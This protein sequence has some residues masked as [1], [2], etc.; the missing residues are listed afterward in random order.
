MSLG[1][2]KA[3]Q[4]IF[5]T[6]LN[7]LILAFHIIC[8]VLMF[9]QG[10]VNPALHDRALSF[11]EFF[12]YCL[13]RCTIFLRFRIMLQCGDM[14]STAYA[15][16]SHGLHRKSH[17]SLARQGSNMPIRIQDDFQNQSGVH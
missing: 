8:Q 9:R 10:Y 6:H 5:F 3:K 17:F 11:M 12:A 4:R 13:P 15:V 14:G 1:Y 16:R 2:T 7:A